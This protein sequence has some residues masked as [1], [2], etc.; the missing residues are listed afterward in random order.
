MTTEKNSKK[1]HQQ[2]RINFSGYAGNVTN[3]NNNNTKFI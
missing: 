1:V 2:S 3:N